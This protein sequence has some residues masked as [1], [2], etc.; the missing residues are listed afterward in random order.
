MKE[1]LVFSELGAQLGVDVSKAMEEGPVPG[2]H[3]NVWRKEGGVKALEY[4]RQYAKPGEYIE[5][6]GH[7]D[8]WLMLAIL[9]ELRMCDL[10]TYIGPFDRALKLCAYRQGAAPRPEQQVT[11]R[12]EEQGENILLTCVLVPDKTPFDLPFEEIVAPKL[13]EGKNIYVRLEGR[14][15]LFAFPVSLTYGETAKAIYMDYAGECFCSV[16]NTSEVAVGDL[17]ENPFAEVR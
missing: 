5:Y 12:V 15:L 9:Y 10:N 14:H 17:V 8:C 7:G 11:F 1:R 4:L 16:S 6:D 2:T 13:R 3:P